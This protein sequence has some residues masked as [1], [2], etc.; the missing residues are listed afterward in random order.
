MP[1]PDQ[2]IAR[3]AAESRAPQPSPLRGEGSYKKQQLSETASPA[4]PGRRW[5]V[6]RFRTRSIPIRLAVALALMAP[7]ALAMGLSLGVPGEPAG[8]LSEG[9]FATGPGERTTITLADGTSIRLGPS[10]RLRL[11]ETAG[12]RTAWLDGRAFFGVETDPSR[13]FT[14]AT[15]H[16]EAKALGTR[17]EVRAEAEE[18]RVLV[19]EGRVEMVAGNVRAELRE[20][21]LSQS[22]GGSAPTTSRVQDVYD[23]LHWMGDVLVFQ[24]TPLERALMEVKRWYGIDAVF[25]DASLKGLT[26]TATFTGQEGRQVAFVLCEI[27]GARCVIDDD[28]IRLQGL[29]D[30][31]LDPE[32]P[33]T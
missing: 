15:P 28:L 2:L 11:R 26:V 10:S 14:V 25:E 13:P 8:V 16:G 22:I 23:H 6:R 33:G 30:V 1:D 9:E 18:F 21:H 12:G 27:V 29:V 5:D 7:V 31:P 32:S 3:A 24:A 20:G 17:F 19:V 4:P